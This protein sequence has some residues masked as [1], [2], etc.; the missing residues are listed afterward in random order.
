[1]SLND[2]SLGSRGRG[3]RCVS[4]TLRSRTRPPSH[5]FKIRGLCP[6]APFFTE[7]DRQLAAAAAVTQRV[8]LVTA[9]LLAPLHTN[10][11][12]LAKQ[13][14]TIDRISGGRLIL[15]L[16]VGNRLDDFEAAG[17]D[18]HRRGR[19]MDKEIG[20]MRRIWA[21]EGGV[22][23]A[24]ARAGGPPI[25]VGGRS[26]AALSRAARLADGWIAGGGGPDLF[27]SGRQTVLERWQAAGRTGSPRFVT[28][29]RF[30]LGPGA[31]EQAEASHRAYYPA[32]GSRPMDATGGAL[33][34][35]DAIKAA[36][37]AF[38]PLGC[39]DLIFGPG[40]A[41]LGQIEALAKVVL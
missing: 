17:S 38:E 4:G 7:I 19:F 8:S 37:A 11:A 29:A 39:D 6:R 41:D 2:A 23:P 10:V 3:S 12:L 20:E 25:L 9:V 31:R 13:A 16:G 26:D 33:L 22:G 35:P 30:A 21:G 1:V 18:F 5:L 40:S 36:V 14:A 27:V 32:G 24:P 28:S 15:G 34:T